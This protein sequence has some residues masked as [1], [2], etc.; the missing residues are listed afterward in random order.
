MSHRWEW[1]YGDYVKG[2]YSF[3]EPTGMIRHVYYE[4]DGNHG[5]RA[6][7][8]LMNPQQSTLVYKS[9]LNYIQIIS[10]IIISKI[11]YK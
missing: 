2:S 9:C 3:L 8:K 10:V 11:R 5:Y 1:R 6:I 7:T 4:V